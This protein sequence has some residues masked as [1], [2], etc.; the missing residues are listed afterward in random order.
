MSDA[1]DLARARAIV[2]RAFERRPHPGADRIAVVRDDCPSYEGNAVARHFG[3]RSWKTIRYDD[4]VADYPEDP[5]ACLAFMT[6]AGFCYY[7]PSF[8]LSALD[9]HARLWADVAEC[10]SSILTRPGAEMP[11]LRARFDAV[12]TE[13]SPEERDAVAVALGALAAEYVRRGFPF[14]PAA[15]AL[16]THWAAERRR[17]SCG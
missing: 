11:S 4:L 17:P 7:L 6:V 5:S 12:A 1:P 3:D 9:S 2:E 16:E 14:N 15:R 8:L 10:V 13:L